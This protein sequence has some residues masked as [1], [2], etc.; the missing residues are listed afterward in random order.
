MYVGL[1]EKVQFYGFLALSSVHSHLNASRSD[2][3]TAQVQITSHITVFWSYESG[4]YF[5]FISVQLLF[6][7]LHVP[8]DKWSFSS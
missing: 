8:N 3:L 1:L 5:L 4:K 2:F 6:C 7:L